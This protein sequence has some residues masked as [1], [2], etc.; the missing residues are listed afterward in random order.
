MLSC[1]CD[2][3]VMRALSDD[4]CEAVCDTASVKKLLTAREMVCTVT[5]RP[6]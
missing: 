5:P 6:M 2:S 1:S 3:M 4:A